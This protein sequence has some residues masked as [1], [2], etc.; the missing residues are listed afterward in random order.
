MP[1]DRL[2]KLAQELDA[3]SRR[4]EMQIRLARQV[5]EQRKSAAA[6][7]HALC[8]A[9]VES[10]NKL[11]SNVKLELAPE[12]FQPDL[13]QETETVLFQINAR[14]RI[15]QIAFEAPEA[16]IS[17][18]NFRIPYILQGEVRWFN[19]ELLEATGVQLHQLFYCLEK[20]GNDWRFYDPKTHRTGL[21]DQDYLIAV[22]EK[23]V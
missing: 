9:F 5:G 3:L 16:S 12:Q 20:S 22:L 21:V 11:V 18:E 2:K 6:D 15:V 4:D 1:K 14:G 7:L 13:F 23:L 19:Q 8:A 17:T 10:V